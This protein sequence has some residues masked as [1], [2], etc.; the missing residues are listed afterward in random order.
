ME[1][2][3]MFGKPVT[4]V[5]YNICPHTCALT[6]SGSVFTCPKLAALAPALCSLVM[7]GERHCDEVPVLRCN[8]KGMSDVWILID[9]PA[10][11]THM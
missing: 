2:A 11:G 5:D 10:G 3:N 8:G 1:R 7:F 6:S 4:Y 9:T